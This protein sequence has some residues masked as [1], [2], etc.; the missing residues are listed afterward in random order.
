MHKNVH[1]SIIPNS[2][3]LET[4]PPTLLE[5]NI[6]QLCNAWTTCGMFIHGILYSNK[7]ES[8][9]NKHNM[10]ESHKH[11]V[12]LKKPDTTENTLYD[13]I[14]IKIKKIKYIIKWHKT[15]KLK[16]SKEFLL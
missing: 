5:T 12:E 4:T 10:E 9:T 6:H 14:Y 16:K 13:S 3:K 11:N 2:S 15:R 7:N 1:S 8:I